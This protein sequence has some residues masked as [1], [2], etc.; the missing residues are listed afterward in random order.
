MPPR[1]AAFIIVR[2][3]AIAAAGGVVAWVAGM[4]AGWM[5]GAMIAVAA[6]AIG[7]LRVHVPVRLLDAVFVVIGALLGTGI[8][9]DIVTR[10]GAWP[11]S[12][13]GLILSVAAMALAVQLYLV[14][15]AGWDRTTAFFTSIPGAFSY[16]VL[17]AAESGADLR[18]VVVGQSIRVFLLVAG[19]PALVAAVEPLPPP[20]IRAVIAPGPL[21]LLLAASLLG[22]LTLHRLRVPG[23]FLSG[24]LLVSGIAY[25]T[26]TVSGTFPLWL[27]VSAYIVLGAMIGSRFSGTTIAFLRS[28]AVAAIGAF[29]VA[30]AVTGVFAVLV[31]EIAN[32]PIGQALVAF[33]PGGLD[34]MAALALAMH[35]DSAFVAV[36][37][38]ARF[39]AIAVVA[40][41][42][43]RRYLK[44]D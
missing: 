6:C 13:A 41:F 21:L 25:G 28:V 15:V 16:I 23:G 39:I 32:V 20:E 22:A 30:V 40:P 29:V 1:D 27:T 44:K 12:L 17:I 31:A 36:H 18:R 3:L 19:I 8:T 4:P 5:S 34:A 43:A 2:T 33:A 10:V 7:G 14:R 42:V 9:P 37:Q 26:G 24:A 35:M 11:L 38:L